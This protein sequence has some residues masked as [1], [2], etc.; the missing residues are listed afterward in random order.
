MNINKPT[1]QEKN[2][3]I[4]AILSEGLQEPEGIGSF[5]I[6]MYNTFGLKYIFFNFNQVIALSIAVFLGMTF[7]LLMNINSYNYTSI[8]LVSPLFF[9]T[10]VSIT[11]WMER[12]NPLFELK[13]TFKYTVKDMI[14]FRTLCYSL[15]SVVLSVVLSLG[16][17]N[18]IEA[19]RAISIAFSSLF[20]CTLLTIVITTRFSHRLTYLTS[21][22]VW[23]AV[24]V[25]PLLVFGKHWE[26]FLSSIPLG[27]TFI[28]SIGLIYLY[29]KELKY[30]INMKKGEV[31][32]D[33]AG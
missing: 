1:L 17:I 29:A 21:F 7:F 4:Q 19:L 24:N 31:E 27:L 9:V 2:Q 15:I 3:A 23:V 22:G 5:F 28:V 12:S 33:V 32:Y 26:T 20:L 30:F 8:F 25:V 18:I 10:V 14:V 6:R 16:M 11:E 13:M